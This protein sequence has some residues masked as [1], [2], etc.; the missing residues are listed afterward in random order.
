M[1]DTSL[2]SFHELHA[3][4]ARS[5]S[6]HSRCE[7]TPRLSSSHR[8]DNHPVVGVGGNAP[9]ASVWLG[10]TSVS[11]FDALE[12][13]FLATA[14]LVGGDAAQCKARRDADSRALGETDRADHAAVLSIR[15]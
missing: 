14:P 5:C 11:R 8:P 10:R 9:H 3:H 7:M 6:T 12:A 4:S 2:T 13:M 1:T 15:R